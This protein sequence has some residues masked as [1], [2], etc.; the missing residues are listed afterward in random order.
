MER[1]KQGLFLLILSIL[2]G[3]FSC[4]EDF[5]V[6]QS[7]TT[8]E[9]TS[10]DEL[11]GLRATLKD[12]KIEYENLTR[13]AVIID[14]DGDYQLVWSEN[15]TIGIFPNQGFQVAFP[16]ASGAGGKTA[17]F[18]GGGWGLKSSSTYSAYC[19]LIGQF[20][21][22]KTKVPIKLT[23]QVQTANNSTEHL[24]AYD[25]MCAINS[26]VNESGSVNFDFSHLVF[27]LHLRLTLPKAGTYRSIVLETNAELTTEAT[28][29][30]TNGNVKKNKSSQVFTLELNNVE[31]SSDNLV[32]DAYMALLPVDL[33]DK[34][35]VAKIFD[36]DNNCYEV[37][38]KSRNYEAGTFYH[39]ARTATVSSANLPVI[40]INTPAWQSITSK[41]EWINK[42]SIMIRNTD[43]TVL[44]APGKIKGRGNATWG[45][46]KKPY[47][48]KFSDKQSPFGFPEN[49]AWVLLAEYND[50]SLLRTSYMCAVSR[51]VGIDYTINYQHVNLFLNGEYQGIYLFTDKIE[52]SKNR[53][54]IDKDGFIIEDD[55]YYVNEPLYFVTESFQRGF[56]FKYPD[57]D[58]GDIVLDDENYLF[59]KEFMNN[60]EL[61]LLKLNTNPSDTEYL[62]Y[63]DLESFAKYYVAAM[64]I[65]LEDPNHYYVLPSRSSKIKRMPMW[66]AE[67][68]L[69]IWPVSAWGEVESILTRDIWNYKAYFTYLKKSPL[70][71]E[72]VKEVWNTIKNKKSV[73]TNEIDAV[74]TALSL[75]QQY[76]FNKWPQSGRV[77]E[78]N[79]SFDT[80]E[81]DVNYVNNF[82]SDRFDW[83]GSY[84]ESW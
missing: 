8:N 51:I 59:I 23:G 72:K 67:W 30:L 22:D 47:A 50:R 16:M 35:L 12:F 46:P 45:L 63:L 39:Q 74:T 79:V 34:T 81:E 4:T 18:D 20:Y 56:T 2:F 38:L 55:N 82:F 13:S 33:T 58:D 40:M 65:E 1:T 73:I 78:M 48:I 32:L 10:S 61:S 53:I 71:K 14:G 27:I 52:D 66:D 49:K 25:Y 7:L 24:S 84:V 43:G 17:R 31:L 44:E 6:S 77:H 9:N 21:L 11:T 57:A 29:D 3:F 42:T 36:T 68:S 54:N 62:D 76:N 26:T 69:G 80:W 28:L 83:F 60:V 19:P 70:F 75:T 37:T 15:D 64:L 5:E 41:D